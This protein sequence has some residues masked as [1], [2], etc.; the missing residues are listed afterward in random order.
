MAAALLNGLPMTATFLPPSRARFS[1]ARRD[2]VLL[3]DDDEETIVIFSAL[4]KRLQCEVVTATTI[5]AA[6]KLLAAQAFGIV[7]TDLRLTGVLGE[8]GLE[9]LRYV[10]EHSPSTAMVLITG[11]GNPEIM[12]RAY[13]LGAAYYF[14]K[15]V[16]PARFIAAIKELKVS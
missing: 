6:E 5:E 13:A 12:T 10:A 8:E 4:L 9:I 14:E 15:P 2:S 7:V 3:I 11:F 16:D 1:T